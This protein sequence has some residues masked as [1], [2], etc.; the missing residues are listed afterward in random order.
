M[1]RQD[2]LVREVIKYGAI[3][4]VVAVVLLDVAAVIEA[5]YAVP[6]AATDAANAAVTR[7]VTT[8]DANQAQDE[9]KYT[10]SLRDMAMTAFRLSQGTGGGGT[11]AYV[12]DTKEVHTYLFHYFT[13]LPWGIGPWFTR[14]LNPKATQ[15]NTQ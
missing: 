1:R 13:G 12:S 6:Q 5:H 7:Y 2:G 15:E 9:A 14:I 3:I 10:L 11:V 8:S 4:V